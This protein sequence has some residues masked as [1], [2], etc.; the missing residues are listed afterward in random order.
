MNTNNRDIRN[1]IVDEEIWIIFIVI[2]LFN[3]VGDEIDKRNLMLNNSHSK[4]AKEIFLFTA[5]IAITIYIYFTIRNYDD[6]MSY[7]NTTYSNLYKERLLGSILIV[8]GSIMIVYFNINVS[9][10]YSPEIP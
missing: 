9:N 4:N 3:I 5:I 6:Y 1:V 7:R 8:V 2:S 10:L